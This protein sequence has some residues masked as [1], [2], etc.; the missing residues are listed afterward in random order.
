MRI[1]KKYFSCLPT[2]AF[3]IYVYEA[4][5]EAE[6]DFLLF[7]CLSVSLSWTRFLTACLSLL[8]KG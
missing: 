6:Y 3:I 7:L 5:N 4:L 1:M 2:F 8:D